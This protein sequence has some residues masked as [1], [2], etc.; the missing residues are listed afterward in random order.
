MLSLSIIKKKC[1]FFISTKQHRMSSSILTQRWKSGSINAFPSRQDEDSN[2]AINNEIPET[3]NNLNVHRKTQKKDKQREKTMDGLT[4]KSSWRGGTEEFKAQ[5]RRCLDWPRPSQLRHTLPSSYIPFELYRTLHIHTFS[6]IACC[7]KSIYLLLI[8]LILFLV[9]ISP[10]DLSH[11]LPSLC[12][13]FWSISY[14]S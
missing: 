6:N 2:R 4:A 13:S 3:A 9:Y 7:S 5:V 14:S 1:F 10:F 11:T 12:I 8:Y